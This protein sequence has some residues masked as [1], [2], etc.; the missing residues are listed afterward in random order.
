MKINTTRYDAILAG[1]PSVSGVRRPQALAANDGVVL[2]L[3]VWHPV[4]LEEVEIHVAWTGDRRKPKERSLHVEA[5]EAS[6]T[7]NQ[8][9][10][11]TWVA[12][13]RPLPS[14]LAVLSADI[15]PLLAAFLEAEVL[16]A[17]ARAIA[18]A[19]EATKIVPTKK[20]VWPWS[21]RKLPESGI[22]APA[23]DVSRELAAVVQA[24][25]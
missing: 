4:A 3:P 5:G 15:Q 21:S 14:E 7:V 11:R 16:Y 12:A 17:T 10:L 18:A 22:P 24:L 6:H 20:P 1:I 8:Q 13:G 25:Q 19:A 9:E 23:L 2:I